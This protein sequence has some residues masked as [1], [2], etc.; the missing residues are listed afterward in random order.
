MSRIYTVSYNGTITNAGGDVDL[1]ELLPADDKPVKL[2]GF[3]FGQT[4]ELG[5]AA[6]ENLAKAVARGEWQAT[7]FALERTSEGTR[8]GYGQRTRVDVASEAEA[9]NVDPKLLRE[10]LVRALLAN[11]ATGE[12]EGGGQ[13][14]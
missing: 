12:D 9:L 14:V 7:Q 6:E 2:V 3:V 13:G 1:V 4:S 11:D 10:R 8:R 5:D